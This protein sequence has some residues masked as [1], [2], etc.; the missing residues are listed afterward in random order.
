M[1]N[2]FPNDDANALVPNFNIGFVPNPGHAHFAN[3][4]NNNG[5]IEWDVPLGEMDEPMVDSESDEEEMDDEDD[6]GDVVD[7][8]NPCPKTIYGKLSLPSHS[9]EL[10]DMM[11]HKEDAEESLSLML[12]A[13]LHHHASMQILAFCFRV[14]S[15]TNDDST[16]YG[17]SNSSGHNSQYEHTSSYSLLA[18]QSSCPQLDHEDLEQLNEFDLEEIDLKWQVAMISMRMKKFYKKTGRSYNLMPRNGGFDKTKTQ[19]LE[20]APQENLYFDGLQSSGHRHRDRLQYQLMAARNQLIMHRTGNK[21]TWLNIKIFNGG[22]V[23]FGGSKKMCDKKN[24]VLFTDT[25]CLVLSLKFKLADENQVLLRIPRQNNMYN[26][27]LENIVPSGGVACLIAKAT[28]DESNKWH[29]QELDANLMFSA[30]ALRIASLPKITGGTF[31]F[32]E[33]A[34][35]ASSV[36][37]TVNTD[38]TPGIVLLVLMVA[39]ILSTVTDL[40]DSEYCSLRIWYDDILLMD[41]T[42]IHPLNLILGDPKSAVQNKEELL[43]FKIQKFGILVDL[44]LWGKKAIGTKWA[45]SEIRRGKSLYEVFSVQKNLDHSDEFHGVIWVLELSLEDDIVVEASPLHYALTVSPVVS[46]TFVEQFWRS[47]KSKS[48]INNVRDC[49]PLFDS[50]LVQPTEDEGDTLERQS[51]P[52]PIPS[53]PH[54][55]GSGGNHGGQSSSDRSLSGNIGGT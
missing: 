40:D 16:A 14:H 39:T 53:P 27:N 10:P 12:K 21:A 4:N 22:S 15:S 26:F 54:L 3:N 28:T 5:W 19:S 9:P 2:L 17:V 42:P 43:Q 11:N 35:K 46:T 1:A 20:D 51:E 37:N 36:L 8:P 33:G 18:N 24:K 49:T 29:R 45:F 25:E 31:F 6:D 13:L 55:K 52:Q 7:A 30:E 44:H 48:I 41:L 34:A 23:A 50:M 47:A 38:S 32:K